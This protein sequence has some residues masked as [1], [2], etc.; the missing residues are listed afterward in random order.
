MT[1]DQRQQT[2]LKEKLL[3]TRSKFDRRERMSTLEEIIKSP[4]HCVAEEDR[5]EWCYMLAE[6]NF[7]PLFE[8]YSAN[9]A[10]YISWLRSK[11]CVYSV[12]PLCRESQIL[13]KEV[14]RLSRHL[15][16]SEQYQIVEKVECVVR[17]AVVHQLDTYDE[18]IEQYGCK[19]RDSSPRLDVKFS[20]LP[21]SASIDNY[22]VQGRVC[23]V[24]VADVKLKSGS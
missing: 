17:H 23:E 24:I 8:K 20:D 11:Q 7:G 6:E 19:R 13:Q 3:M 10:D 1:D 5:K 12:S 16:W 2:L 14:S 15:D 18:L 4:G 21:L 9:L 22:R